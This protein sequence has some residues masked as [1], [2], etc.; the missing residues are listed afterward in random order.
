MPTLGEIKKAR[1]LG[2]HSGSKLI[3]QACFVCG[4]ERWV[5]M[6]EG[7]P[8]TIYCRTCYPKIETHAQSN[9]NW[10]GGRW[11]RP[12]GYF[13]IYVSIDDFFRP[14]AGKK[15]YAMEHRLVMAKHLGRNLQKWEIIH[16]KNG[17]R[18]DNRIENLELIGSISEHMSGHLRGYQD[19]YTKGL[20]DG[21][22][23]QIEELKSL[24]EEQTKQIRFLQWQTN[25]RQKSEKI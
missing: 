18:D 25:E 10:K 5:E 23:K 11:K 8:E 14:T 22:D 2:Q 12:D 24:I 17:I 21:K 4:K 16:H 7:E 9:R 19:G 1:D 20:I 3:W 6:R 13:R 15:G